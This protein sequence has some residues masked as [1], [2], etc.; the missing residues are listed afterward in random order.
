M[1]PATQS[2]S[3]TQRRARARAEAFAQAQSHAAQSRPSSSAPQSPGKIQKSY[4]A[5]GK[6]RCPPSPST[7][8]KSRAPDRESTPS[9]ANSSSQPTP[10]TPEFTIEVTDSTLADSTDADADLQEAIDGYCC[11]QDTSNLSIDTPSKTRIDGLNA[12]RGRLSLLEDESPTT[13]SRSISNL[14]PSANDRGIRR[15]L[16]TEVAK[17]HNRSSPKGSNADDKKSGYVYVLKPEQDKSSSEGNGLF[18]FKVGRSADLKT[19][20]ENLEKTCQ[21]KF[22]E[23]T[24]R[25]QRFLPQADVA[26]SLAKLELAPWKHEFDCVCR[27]KHREYFEVTEKK[28]V[29]VVQ[30]WTRFY[31]QNPWDENGLLKAFWLARLDEC[32][33][34]WEPKEHD[35]ND[36]RWESF[37][38]PQFWEK[39]W[40]DLCALFKVLITLFLINRWPLLYFVQGMRMM[41]EAGE[42]NHALMVWMTIGCFMM[43]VDNFNVDSLTVKKFRCV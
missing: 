27:I 11:G 9:A 28:A 6:A 26:E 33:E 32:L 17:L 29:G 37:T 7:P 19:R 8:S 36:N 39:P 16:T 22:E 4:Q 2:Q 41:L 43:M 24:I 18:V 40:F 20:I 42:V 5:R 1:A 13:R 35:L 21:R 15:F 25:R 31:R 12:S 23:I 30:R 14:D 10:H 3:Q 38:Q 34:K